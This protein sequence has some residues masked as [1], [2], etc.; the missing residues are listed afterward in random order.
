MKKRVSV[1]YNGR[2]HSVGFRYTA[3][4]LALSRAITGFVR[5]VPDGTVEIVAEGEET[6][7]KDFLSSLE[8]EMKGH[9]HSSNV[10]WLPFSGEFPDFSIK[11]S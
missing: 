7:I 9:I 2:V 1:T 6:E 4:R 3:E 11:Y 10:S 8:A 5:N